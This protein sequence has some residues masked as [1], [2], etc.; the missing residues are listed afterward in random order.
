[1]AARLKVATQ[2]IAVAV[3]AGLLAL[4]VWKIVHGN[5]SSVSS[6]LKRGEQPAAPGF[7][8]PR[9]DKK[10]TLS[11]ASLRGK[12]VVLN[13]WASWCVPC[14]AEAPLLEAAWQH[15]R[16]SGVVVLGIDSQDFSH[17]ARIFMRHHDVTYPVVHDGAGKLLASWGVTGFPET[18]FVARS[19]KAVGHVPGQVEA[20]QLSQNIRLALRS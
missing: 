7:S 4:L 15:Y 5:G 6:A 11:L 20:G 10:G 13:F 1:M 2:A 9:L 19:G 12:V 8:L 16:S 17:D 14:K 18:F 3:V